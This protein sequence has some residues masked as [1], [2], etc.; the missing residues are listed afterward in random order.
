MLLA[1]G[2]EIVLAD[3]DRA[4][5]G[6]GGVLVLGGPM[7]YLLSQ[8]VYWRVETGTGWLPRAAGAAVIGAAACMAYWPPA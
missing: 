2:I 3:A 4:D 1:A 6:A 5:A 8:A 7:I